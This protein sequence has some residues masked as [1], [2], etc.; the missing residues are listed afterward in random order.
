MIHPTTEFDLADMR[1]RRLEAALNS[2]VR[3]KAQGLPITW[4]VTRRTTNEGDVIEFFPSER[5]LSPTAALK[6]VVGPLDALGITGEGRRLRV[7]FARSLAL[8]ERLRAVT[9]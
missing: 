5:N 1:R 3:S 7:P 2:K 4:V 6:A 9:P 8:L